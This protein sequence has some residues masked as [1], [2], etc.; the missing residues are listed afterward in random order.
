[1]K[2]VSPF[3][4]DKSHLHHL[5]IEIGFSHVGTAACVILLN[6]LNIFCWFVSY[7]LG[8]NATVQFL[9]VVFVGFL[10]TSGIYYIVRRMNHDRHPYKVLK[11]IAELSHVETGPFYKGMRRLMDR[12]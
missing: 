3:H 1:M 9:V 10:N 11:R 12:M 7:Q 5:F 6:A 8:A 4:A 2:G